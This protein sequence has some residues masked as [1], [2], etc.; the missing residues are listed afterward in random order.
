MA[1]SFKQYVL[2]FDAARKDAAAIT[3]D[4]ILHELNNLVDISSA[5]IQV[6]KFRTTVRLV[7][8][9]TEDRILQICDAVKKVLE[10]AFNERLLYQVSVVSL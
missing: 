8:T 10:Q 9:I 3:S 7:T 6:D 4:R 2:S 1:N 5:D